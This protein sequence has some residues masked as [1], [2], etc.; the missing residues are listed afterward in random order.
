MTTG[1]HKLQQLGDLLADMGSVVV[2]YSGGVDSSFVAAVAHQ[3]LG[4]HCLA[5]T[6]S[7]PS[8]SPWELE[9]AQEL[10]RRLGWHHRVIE[11]HEVE[12]PGYVANGARR[13]YFCK[14]HLYSH[15]IAIAR[16]E[17]Y[18]L[19]VDG[20]N[21]DDLEEFRPGQD[22]ARE[23]GIRS[24]LVEAN[25]TKEEIRELS[26]EMGLPTWDKPAQA[27]LAS[28]VPYGT[29]VT[30]DTLN[31]I[32]RAERCLRELGFR[33]L[34]VR[35]HGNTARIELAPEDISQLMEASRRRAV[36]ERFKELGY[37]YVTLDLE[38][39]RAGS[40]NRVLRESSLRGRRQREPA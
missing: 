34:R 11:T 17:G 7:S 35:H 23:W 1:R 25:L 39:Y 18:A 12:E 40:L 21:V 30:I 19:V 38:G 20:A 36:V 6:A 5:V 4:S 26:R 31:Q 8:L 16:E 33:Q 28:R 13:C 32:A 24:P 15:F 2:A 10:A 29:L 14:N 3:K 9:E 37:L 27:C 22:A